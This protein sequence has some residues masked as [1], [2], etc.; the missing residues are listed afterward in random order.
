MGFHHRMVS[1]RSAPAATTYR[2][3]RRVGPWPPSGP[4]SGNAPQRLR[5]LA[6]WP[7]WSNTSTPY[8]GVGGRTSATATR[9]GSS[10]PSTAT[11]TAAGQARQRQVRAPRL[12][13]GHPFYLRV[14]DQP[15][16]LPADRHGALLGC[17]CLTMNGVGEP[18]AG[19]PHARFDR[20]PLASRRPW[21]GGT[22]TQRET[23]GTEP[24]RPTCERATSGLPHQSRGL[25][26]LPASSGYAGP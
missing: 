21:R 19:E 16:D 6:K 10:T 4:R 11:S 24:T 23:R 3:G 26:E 25:G 18:C 12:E 9:H 20:G 13:L 14:A 1:R 7:W 17:A 15:R 22:R 8:C 2:S 5:Q